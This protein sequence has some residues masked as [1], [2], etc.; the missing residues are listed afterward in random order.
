M[1]VLQH[2]NGKFVAAPGGNHSYTND[3]RQAR[4]FPTRDAAQRDRCVESETIVSL[5]SLLQPIR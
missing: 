3:I 2:T 4:R 5:E 1:Y